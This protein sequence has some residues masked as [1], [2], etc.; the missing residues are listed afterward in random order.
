[1]WLKNCKEGMHLTHLA[2]NNKKVFH[3]P[4]QLTKILKYVG[5]FIFSKKWFFFQV[6]PWQC[7]PSIWTFIEWKSWL[8][9]LSGN[10]L[11]QIFERL[12]N[13]LLYNIHLI[14]FFAST[15][16]S[17]SSSIWNLFLW[18][19]S[20]WPKSLLLGRWIRV[21]SSMAGLRFYQNSSKFPWNS[22]YFDNGSRKKS[23]KSN[24]CKIVI[25]EPLN[26]IGG[27][28]QTTLTRFWLFWPP[29]GQ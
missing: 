1:M 4:S 16:V 5:M 23:S 8:L 13:W 3:P 9:K 10:D 14:Q 28:S 18:I 6:D 12:V 24:Y 7:Y 27:R 17:N 26:N 19:V 15:N 2:N 22:K 29:K 25:K 11:S 21:K 20:F